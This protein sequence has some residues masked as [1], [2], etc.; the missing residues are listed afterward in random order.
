MEGHNELASW[1]VEEEQRVCKTFLKNLKFNKIPIWL[2]EGLSNAKHLG[3]RSGLENL[4]ESGAAVKKM[5]TYVV[6][7]ADIDL[8]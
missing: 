4:W 1:L 5:A 6:N 3:N 7:K 2:Q 8:V